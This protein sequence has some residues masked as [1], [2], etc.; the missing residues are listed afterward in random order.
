MNKRIVIALGGNALLDPKADGSVAEQIRVIERSCEKI[1]QI[2][3][4]GYGVVVTHGNGPQVGNLL[5]QQEEAK[6]LVPSLPL[7]VCDAM[8]QGQLGYW[9]QQKLREVLARRGLA[10]SVVTVVTQVR[11]DPNDPAFASPTKPIGPFYS[12]SERLVLEQKGYV[13]RR[14]GQGARA[15]RRVVA[16]PDPKEIVEL[17]PIR[18]LLEAGVVVI[19]CGGGGVPV[20]C[21]DGHWRGVE[22]VID[23]DL[24]SA[25]LAIEL[26]AHVLLILTDVERVALH[27]GTPRQRLLERMS[28][29]EARKYLSEG[30]FPAGSMGPKVEAAIRFLEAGGER[31][32]ITSL[33]KALEA[34]EGRAGTEVYRGL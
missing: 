26:G 7:D 22:A 3:A 18:A 20:V 23:K 27:F 10:K 33:E 21:E 6:E 12:E 31:A 34:L 15:W 13:L 29:R 4:Q 32:C 14:V 30:H 9:I 8:T 2:I 25:L 16:S 28:V 24:A 19:A 1:A 11:V 5:I 17:E